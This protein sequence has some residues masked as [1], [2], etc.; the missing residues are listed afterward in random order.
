MAFNLNKI[1]ARIVEKG[2][3]PQKLAAQIELSEGS[4][5]DKLAGNCAF[6]REDIEKI[7]KVLEIPS[8]QIADYF[9]DL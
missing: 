3:S 8:D 7:C 6:K 2:L 9:F 4:V 5:Y 1:K